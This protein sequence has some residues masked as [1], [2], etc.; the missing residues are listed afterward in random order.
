[1]GFNSGF[2]GLRERACAAPY[3]AVWVLAPLTVSAYATYDAACG[4]AEATN[5]FYAG[6][7]FKSAFAASQ[8]KNSV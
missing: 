1:M 4:P 7:V 5:L 2:K 6:T 3:R 8:Y